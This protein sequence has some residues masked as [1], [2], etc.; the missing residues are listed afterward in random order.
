M[1]LL[2]LETECD[3]STRGVTRPPFKRRQPFPSPLLPLGALNL[4]DRKITDKEILGGEN[5][6]TG[7]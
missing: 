3:M 7:K 1:K 4:Q 2:E 5:C 6:R